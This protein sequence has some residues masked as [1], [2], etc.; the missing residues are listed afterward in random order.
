M[1]KNSLNYALIFNDITQGIALRFDF[2]FYASQLKAR[3]DVPILALTNKLA[4][5]IYYKNNPHKVEIN[6]V[7]PNDELRQY[8]TEIANLLKLGVV[9]DQFD[10]EY[11][12]SIYPDVA[13]YKVQFP[14][15]C[16]HHW[17]CYGIFEH[18]QFKFHERVAKVEKTSVETKPVVKAETKPFVKVETKPFVKAEIKP[19]V[20]TEAEKV[21]TIEKP[22]SSHKLHSQSRHK[23]VVKAQFSPD[24]QWGVLTEVIQLALSRYIANKVYK[25]QM[26]EMLQDYCQR[27]ITDIEEAHD[28]FH[29]GRDQVLDFM[30]DFFKLINLKGYL[31][32]ISTGIQIE[33]IMRLLSS[34]L[35]LSKD[36]FQS[37]L[38]RLC[39]HT[40]VSCPVCSGGLTSSATSS[41]S[42]L[43]PPNEDFLE[44]LKKV[45]EKSIEETIV[46]LKRYQE[47]K[48]DQT[49]DAFKHI[50][51]NSM[52]EIVQSVKKLIRSESELSQ[53]S[54]IT[55]QATSNN[56]DFL[57]EFRRIQESST[58]QIMSLLSQNLAELKDLN[59]IQANT[60]LAKLTDIQMVTS[61]MPATTATVSS[62][63]DVNAQTTEQ[64]D[65]IAV[66]QVVH[67]AVPAA[68]VHVV[69]QPV[70]QAVLILNQT[71]EVIPKL[72]PKPE[73]F[74]TH[75]LA[76]SEID[77]LIQMWKNLY[78]RINE[79]M[80]LLDV[81][82]MASI[83]ILFSL[84]QNRYDTVLKLSGLFT[85][86]FDQL[87]SQLENHSQSLT[88][89]S[90][91]TLLVDLKSQSLSIKDRIR[92]I[93]EKHSIK[94]EDIHQLESY[95]VDLQNQLLKLQTQMD[96]FHNSIEGRQTMLISEFIDN[97][98]MCLQESIFH[99]M[100]RSGQIERFNQ[101]LVKLIQ[102]AIIEKCQS[103]GLNPKVLVN[104]N[105]QLI[106][107]QFT[108]YY[109]D[110]MGED[111][112]VSVSL[113]NS[114]VKKQLANFIGK[115]IDPQSSRPVV[116][117][118]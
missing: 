8:Q 32:H 15:P 5:W 36:K 107:D 110:H 106:A 115:L 59:T 28:F 11:Y 100:D 1:N 47:M 6:L 7:Q 99:L 34:K 14:V 81:N 45:Q 22:E 46:A 38:R 80:P 51:E 60:V 43:L 17:L 53:S 27:S 35:D 98:I 112:F 23:T 111:L 91:T 87:F 24:A 109:Q 67:Q 56:K 108:A 103:A 94:A 13:N 41:T 16:F 48:T 113:D 97:L 77:Q 12:L 29:W 21:E 19:I 82:I 49:Y 54:M 114:K 37:N 76:D 71:N 116:D 85:D 55:A 20:K 72:N 70:P 102:F 50:H 93:E 26:A 73:T 74:P 44:F 9:P 105:Y 104:D 58:T 117:K 64:S 88:D 30:G 65:T 3:K 63:L 52:Q 86:G 57:D 31:D 92:A 75:N 2:D 83:E 84:D 61:T 69:P 4:M 62:E 118:S 40:V 66:H 33:S 96:Q 18:R 89:T 25:R 39:G 42:Q 79:Q 78:S 68:V 10:S 101:Q 95:L 90:Q